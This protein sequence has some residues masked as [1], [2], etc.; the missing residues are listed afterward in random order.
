LKSIKNKLKLVKNK[1]KL[2]KNK[3]TS[4]INWPKNCCGGAKKSANYKILSNYL[5][6]GRPPQIN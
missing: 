6:G 3:L 4:L 2:I 1:L 5:E